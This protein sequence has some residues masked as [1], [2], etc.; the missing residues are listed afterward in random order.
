[1]TFLS[2]NSTYTNVHKEVTGILRMFREPVKGEKRTAIAVVVV[3]MTPEYLKAVCVLHQTL[4]EKDTSFDAF[5]LLHNGIEVSTI[6][7]LTSRGIVCTSIDP[8]QVPGALLSELAQKSKL[9]IEN[10]TVVFQKLAIF[11][12]L[13]LYSR[14]LYLD[15]DTLPLAPLSELLQ[16]RLTKEKPIATIPEKTGLEPEFNAGVFVFAPELISFQ[17]MISHLSDT[18]QSCGY[19]ADEQT[20]LCHYFFNRTM[21]LDRKYNVLHKARHRPEFAESKDDWKIVHFNGKK[22][23]D[24]TMEEDSYVELWRQV[25]KRCTC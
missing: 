24:V 23:W 11:K 18:K 15:V 4:M 19:R 12:E 5:H 17:D 21:V 16:V 2:L 14:V 25:A 3:N 1:M 22:P 7:L 20:Y 9:R 13:K 10:K 8:V 6:K